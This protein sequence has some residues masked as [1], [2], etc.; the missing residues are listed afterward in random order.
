MSLAPTHGRYAMP[1]AV[2]R[3][4]M[5]RWKYAGQPCVGCTEPIPSRK[6]QGAVGG[7]LVRGPYCSL[8]CWQQAETVQL[9]HLIGREWT[10]DAQGRARKATPDP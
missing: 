6:P 1:G 2:P 7:Q 5:V 9:P 4:G 8:A 10:R 3:R